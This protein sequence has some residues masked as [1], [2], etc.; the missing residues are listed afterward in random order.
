M[1]LSN[2]L[3]NTVA[4]KLNLKTSLLQGKRFY[5]RNLLNQITQSKKLKGNNYKNLNVEKNRRSCVQAT[6]FQGI[7]FVSQH[8]ASF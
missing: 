4:N 5:V 6:L 7:F 3:F 8:I 2:I 1:N